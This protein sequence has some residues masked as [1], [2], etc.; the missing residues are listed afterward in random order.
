IEM[1]FVLPSRFYCLFSYSRL[2][3]HS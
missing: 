3:K 1:V 2:G